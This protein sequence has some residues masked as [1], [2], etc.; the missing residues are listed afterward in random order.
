MVWKIIRRTCLFIIV[1]ML[2]LVTGLVIYL[3]TVEVQLTDDD[4]PQNVYDTSQNVN[5]MMV[6][7]VTNILTSDEQ[8]VQGYIETFLN[9]M[10]YKTIRDDINPDYD[11]I[12]GESAESQYIIKNFLMEIDYVYANITDDEQLLLTVSMK[13]H[14]FPKISTAMYFYFDMDFNYT[15]MTLSLILDHVLI[16]DQEV[17]K[18]TYDF[19]LSF[20]NKDKIEEAIDKGSL[21]L[22]S[23]TYQVGF[24]DYLLPF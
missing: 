16:D 13:R 1:L 6:S 2:L 17:S 9:V 20:M 21:D 4:L 12:L 5:I 8:N 3:N 10:I 19:I 15:R 24:R 23:Y 11:P 14:V 18:S 22:E 7:A